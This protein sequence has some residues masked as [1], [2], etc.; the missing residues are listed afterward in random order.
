MRSLLVSFLAAVAA[1][2]IAVTS[3]G[4]GPARA[5]SLDP[6]LLVYHQITNLSGGTGYMGF[7]VLSA[8]GSRVAFFAPDAGDAATPNRIYA[9]GADG[10]GLTEVDSYKPGCGC[11]SEVSISADGGTVVSTDSMQV[12]LVAAGGAARTVVAF[13]SNEVSSIRLTAAGA[14]VFFVLGRDTQLS[15]T[16]DTLQRGIYAVD[17]EGGAPHLVVGPDAIAALL[18]VTADSVNMLRLATQVLDVSADGSRLVFGA[19]VGSE[20]D[21]FAAAGNGSDLHRVAGPVQYAQR[22]AISS[23]GATIAYDVVPQNGDGNNQI[24]VGPYGGGK[25]RVV[26]KATNSGSSDPVQLSADGSH[27]LI[28]PNSLLIDTA[29]GETRQLGVA[30]PSFGGNHDSVL[31]DGLPRATMNAGATRFAYAMRTARCAD[32]LNAHEQLATLDL[33]ATDLGNAPR[34]V[35]PSATPDTIALGGASAA[36]VQVNVQSVGK[37]RGVGLLV[38]ADGI[39]DSHVGWGVNLVDDGTNGDAAANDG[40]FTNNAV[41][42][43]CCAALGPHTLRIAVEVETSDGLRHATAVD[44]GPLTVVAQ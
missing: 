39:F 21:V 25:A 23:G 3:V 30:P 37:L 19:W 33:G 5:Q 28:S 42:A 10:T 32:C 29:T 31:T 15:G 4:A 9:V 20:Q 24:A 16:S 13:D 8:D 7:P 2:L 22:V 14:R 1:L 26:A 12:R 38:L 44:F 40:T 27:L 18:G 17:A 41:R 36:T 34:L 35:E 43:D 6:N 11:N